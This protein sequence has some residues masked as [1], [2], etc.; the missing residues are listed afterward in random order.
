MIARS[1]Y[2]FSR[3]RDGPSTRKWEIVV[4]ITEEYP[5]KRRQRLGAGIKNLMT[6]SS[7]ALAQTFSIVFSLKGDVGSE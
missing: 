1:L 3:S 2:K 6:R 4:S 5:S 7:L